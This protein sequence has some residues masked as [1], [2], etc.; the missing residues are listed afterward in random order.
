VKALLVYKNEETRWVEI[1]EYYPIYKEIVNVDNKKSHSFNF[2]EQP[3]NYCHQERIFIGHN[4]RDIIIYI[5][6]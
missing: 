6:N 1:K 2:S 4:L 3:T 5:E